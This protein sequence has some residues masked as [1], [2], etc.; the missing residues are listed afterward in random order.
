M[1][2]NQGVGDGGDY[3]VLIVKLI[4]RVYYVLGNI[5]N[6]MDYQ[7]KRC[8]GILCKNG[9]NIVEYNNRHNH[10]MPFSD[11]QITVIFFIVR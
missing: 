5:P 2:L 4:S 1:I 6:L 11:V 7:E 8:D 10:L 9:E 3:E